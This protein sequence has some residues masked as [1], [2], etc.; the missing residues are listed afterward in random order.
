MAEETFKVS[1]DGDQVKAMEAKLTNMGYGPESLEQGG[2]LPETHGVVLAY[3]VEMATAP[4][5]AVVTFT[6]RKKPFYVGLGMI[7]SGV[8]QMMGIA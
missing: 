5:S 1:L 6:V 4:L 8:K 2:V 3:T 7:E